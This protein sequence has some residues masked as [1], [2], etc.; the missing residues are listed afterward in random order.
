MSTALGLGWT[1]CSRLYAWRLAE[2]D[3][4]VKASRASSMPVA[5]DLQAAGVA[6]IDHQTHRQQTL[7]AGCC[8]GKLLSGHLALQSRCMD[9]S[10][11]SVMQHLHKLTFTELCTS[12]FISQ[13]GWT[14]APALA[15]TGSAVHA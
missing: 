3:C 4:A 7:I 5:G 9:V 14:L 11:Q 1:T 6:C 2:E 12:W 15:R 10:K 8:C 13:P